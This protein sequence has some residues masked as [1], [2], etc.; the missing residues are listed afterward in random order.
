MVSKGRMSGV[1]ITGTDT[2]VGKTV[3]TAAVV[4]ALRRDGIDAVGMKPV[5]TGRDREVT[6]SAAAT[7]KSLDAEIIA[8]YSC[9]ES[10]EYELV[11]PVFLAVE[12]APYMASIMLKQEIDIGRVLRAYRR[13][14]ER[15][16]FIVV[17]GIGGVM[18]PIK[19]DYYVL[20]LIKDLKLPALIV[21][22]ARLGTINHTLLTVEACRRRGIEV[23]GIVM[24]MI[25]YSNPVEANAG[26]IIHELSNIP[27]IGSIPYI[28]DMADDK[29]KI[30]SIAKYIRYELLLT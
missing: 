7:A 6:T 16:E 11:N 17:E 28:K 13:L 29:D 27:I 24:N 2:G 4:H 22:R 1:F 26:D 8:R 30:P 19:R 25:D 3:V 12:A 15:H 23:V 5:A 21:A 9:I 14:K 18:V 20:D 10:D